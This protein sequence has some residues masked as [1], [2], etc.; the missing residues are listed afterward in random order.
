MAGG[1]G[2]GR[3]TKRDEKR[4]GGA[5]RRVAWDRGGRSGTRRRVR[6][7]DAGPVFILISSEQGGAG[8]ITK[9]SAASR[10]TAATT[11]HSNA[12]TS[13]RGVCDV[14]TFIYI[15]VRYLV[16]LQS[17]PVRDSPTVA[18]K[19]AL[20]GHGDPTCHLQADFCPLWQA[21]RPAGRY[22]AL[23]GAALT[24]AS[25]VVWGGGGDGGGACQ[26]CRVRAASAWAPTTP[27]PPSVSLSSRCRSAATARRGSPREAPAAPAATTGWVVAPPPASPIPPTCTADI[28]HSHRRPPRSCPRRGPRR[29]RRRGRGARARARTQPRRAHAAA[30]A[31]RGGGAGRRARLVGQWTA[32]WLATSG[33]CHGSS[34][35]SWCPWAGWG[36]ESGSR[37]GRGEVVG[38]PGRPLRGE[39]RVAALLG[40]AQSFVE[41]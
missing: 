32:A 41:P 9:G 31:Q 26:H 39:H 27:H 7:P 2:R 18:Q 15:S 14:S 4:V 10:T 35:W 6:G 40:A 36:G 29:R 1:T 20:P 17:F 12:K 8:P 19:S 22:T 30:A 33:G 38:R 11:C 16:T 13:C 28:S 3:E 24:C 37:G 25:G 5:W 34:W 21:R 23:S